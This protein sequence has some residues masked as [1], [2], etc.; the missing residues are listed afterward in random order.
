MATLLNQELEA[1]ERALKQKRIDIASSE[2]EHA[3]SIKTIKLKLADLR[4]KERALS[5]K[6]NGRGFLGLV[7]DIL[8]P[9]SSGNRLSSLRVHIRLL[10]DELSKDQEPQKKGLRQLER[11]YDAI[12]A[13]LPEL[14]SLV[15]IEEQIKSTND[16]IVVSLGEYDEAMQP[17]KAMKE[18][19]ENRENESEADQSLLGDFLDIALMSTV[20]VVELKNR[21]SFAGLK[22]YK[23]VMNSDDLQNRRDDRISGYFSEAAKWDGPKLRAEI[24]KRKSERDAIPT[25]TLPNVTLFTV[26]DFPLKD[27]LER[28]R[29]F[30]DE[31]IAELSQPRQ[32]PRHDER[33]ERD[34]REERIKKLRAERATVM[35]D[36]QLDAHERQVRI[37][38]Y[39][40]KIEAELEKFEPL[41]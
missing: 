31:V 27:P 6:V 17:V 34:Q 11:S 9:M 41:I 26:K 19:Y 10:E 1:V 5:Q 20:N 18:H 16:S 8:L 39:D 14:E 29:Q 2:Q 28:Q 32:V 23:F 21:V 15:D 35:A 40:D 33:S 36:Q 30:I 38:M 3:E 7:K 24:R 12:K 4:R 22:V 25:I 13:S 37:N